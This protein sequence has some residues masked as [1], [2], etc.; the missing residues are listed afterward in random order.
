MIKYRMIDE[1]GYIRFRSNHGRGR[2]S[3]CRWS[4]NKLRYNACKV[5]YR[6]AKFGEGFWRII[7][8]G[9]MLDLDKSRARARLRF[10][11]TA[12]D[13]DDRVNCLVVPYIERGRKA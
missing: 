12:R 5:Q 3:W 7:E 9:D 4:G 1:W 6:H 13:R 8:E 2:K 11:L 10:P